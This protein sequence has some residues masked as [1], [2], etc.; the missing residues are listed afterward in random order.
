MSFSFQASG[1]PGDAIRE[2]GQ[3]AAIQKVP[4]EFADAINN[5]LAG[6]PKNAAVRVT[7]HGHT[8][9]GEAQTSGTLSLHVDIEAVAHAPKAAEPAEEPE[10]EAE[11]AGDE[12]AA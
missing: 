4:Q 1:S 7:A 12:S 11:A 9:W 6:L 5:Q 3:Q 2:V 8:G 10:A